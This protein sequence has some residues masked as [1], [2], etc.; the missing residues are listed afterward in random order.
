[1]QSGRVGDHRR[2]IIEKQA[3][4]LIALGASN[5]SEEDADFR[6]AFAILSIRQVFEG[7]S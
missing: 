5:A 7:D 4:P 2:R 3:A 1:L 6:Q